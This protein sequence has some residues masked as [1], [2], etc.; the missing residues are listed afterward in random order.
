[1]QSYKDCLFFVSRGHGDLV[2]SEEGIQEGEYSLS[3]GGVYNLVYPRQ[4]ETIFWACIIEVDVI[5]AHLPLAF[6]FGNH[7]H[8][9]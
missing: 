8:I 9:C 1:M 3:G 2:V 5:D 7:Y 4:R 6:L